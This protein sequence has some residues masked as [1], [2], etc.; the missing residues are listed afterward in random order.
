MERGAAMFIQE[1]I[2]I[3]GGSFVYRVRHRMLEGDCPIEHGPVLCAL[4]TFEITKYPVTNGMYRTYCE[5][6]GTTVNHK[7]SEYWEQN[8][9]DE[10]ADLPCGNI[11]PQEAEAYCAF[12]GARLP[13]EAEWQ[14]AAGGSDLRRF[15]WGD[16]LL[17]TY[18]DSGKLSPV[19]AHPE[20]DSPFGV[21][22]MCGNAR[23]FTS[24]IINDGN[25]SFIMLRGGCCYR[26]AHAWHIDGG[27]KSIDSHCK[28]LLLNDD[29]NRSPYV[30][31]R[32]V[33][34]VKADV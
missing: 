14:Y 34:E 15:P 12:Y 22:D 33:R 9:F 29:S 5:E 8:A 21:S 25:H 17:P 13:T 4:P 31:F 6:S 16:D 11:T 23:E 32:C 18:V 30:G 19:H 27:C 7:L 1:W 2:R 26:A 24:P 20:G 3:P 10:I 28:M